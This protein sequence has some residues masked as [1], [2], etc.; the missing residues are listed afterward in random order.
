MQKLLKRIEALHE[1]IRRRRNKRRIAWPRATDPVLRSP[2]FTGSLV[3]AATSSEQNRMHLANQP[4]RERESV[5]QA[6]QSVLHRRYV[7]RNFFHIVN[8]HS[9]RCVVF[10][11]QQLRK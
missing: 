11:K 1:P 6:A 8:G 7:I 4:Q 2:E 10:K 5:A 9:G 3:R